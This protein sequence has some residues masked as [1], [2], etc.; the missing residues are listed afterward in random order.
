MDKWAI[1][2]LQE[3]QVMGVQMSTAKSRACPAAMS[4]IVPSPQDIVKYPIKTS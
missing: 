2:T 1:V 4:K 3:T